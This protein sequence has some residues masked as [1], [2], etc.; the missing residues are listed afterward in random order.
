MNIYSEEPSL[1]HL[2][3]PTALEDRGRR[4]RERVEAFSQGEPKSSPEFCV[5]WQPD[6][7]ELD[8]AVSPGGRMARAIMDD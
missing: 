2:A 6:L 3:A 8:T 5:S 7:V 1:A 4:W